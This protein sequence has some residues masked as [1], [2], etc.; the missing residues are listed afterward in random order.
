MAGGAK[1][2]TIDVSNPLLTVNN[3]YTQFD[4]PRGIAR[5]VDG[6]SFSLERGKTLGIVGESGSGK[7]VLS[8]T[9]I[10]IL[11]KDDSVLF[12]GEII[13]E[14]CDLR[15]LSEREMQEIRGKEIAMVFQ[16][17]MSS[18]NPVKKIGKQI[19]EVLTKRLGMSSHLA[20]IRAV[21]L[22]HSVGIPDPEQQLGRYPMHLSGGMRQRIAIAI[23]I[24]SE[25][26]LLIADEPTT[27]LDV[28][29]QAQIL[30]LLKEQQTKYNMSI[31]LIT[32]NLGIVSGY[33]DDVAVMYAGKIVEK[34]STS[35]LISNPVMPY[36]KALMNSA[37]SLTNTPHTRLQAIPG[38]PPNLLNLPNG[39]SF[40]S[41]CSYN[42][43]KCNKY[44]PDQTLLK[45]SMHSFAC[46]HPLNRSLAEGVVK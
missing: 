5:A 34:C 8:R 10:D 21:E 6:V 14:G 12:D 2:E 23:A 4:T 17:P 31:I 25:P 1:L 44:T 36:T 16:D 3:L 7:S 11:A 28:T 42:D 20:K 24:A 9:I 37:P 41:R 15:T 33:T 32:H 35:E 22:I 26:K 40:H 39:C 38:L 29:I 13:F 46:W 30:E 19:T 27:A 45:D 43:E 18:L